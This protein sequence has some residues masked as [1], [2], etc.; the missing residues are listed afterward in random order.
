M[1]TNNK[2]DYELFVTTIIF[3]VLENLLI[4]LPII[5]IGMI[6]KDL[7]TSQ[8]IITVVNV[9]ITTLSYATFLMGLIFYI[10]KNTRNNNAIIEFYNFII[11]IIWGATINMALWSSIFWVL[12]YYRLIPNIVYDIR[13]FIVISLIMSLPFVIPFYVFFEFGDKIFKMCQKDNNDNN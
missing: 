8:K 6:F 4:T 11:E 10:L 7:T 9:I 12:S 2:K 13:F 5:I 1:Y 3:V